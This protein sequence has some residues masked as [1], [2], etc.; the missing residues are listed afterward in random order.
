MTP[1]AQAEFPARGGKLGVHRHPSTSI[2]LWMR[3]DRPRHTGMEHWQGPHSRIISATPGLEEYRQIHLAE[4]NPGLWPRADGIETEIPHGR[5]ADGVAEVTFT[6][7]LSPTRGR[8]QT[9]LA[10][11]DEV[12][13]FRRTL[14]YAA[15]P[16]SSRWY[17]VANSGHTGARA[18]VYLRRRPDTGGRAFRRFVA[19]DLATHLAA[20]A[21]LTELRTQL[22]IPWSEKT[23]DTPNV[24][25]DNPPD[26]RFHASIILGFATHAERDAY[27]AGPRTA[28][29]SPVLAELVSAVHAYDVA[30]VLT[31]VER[32]TVLDSPR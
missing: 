21:P 1:A 13:V 3:T 27:F 30:N 29:L 32:G 10:H 20:S 6:S 5:K 25:H 14:L 19:R 26:Q 4:K 11:Q 28:R 31:F 12:N 24:Q 17:D 18:L 2:L 8:A 7:L 15:L 23:W 9:K 22:F 16:S